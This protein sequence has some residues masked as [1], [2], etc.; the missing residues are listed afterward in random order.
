MTRGRCCGWMLMVVVATPCVAQP[1]AA[2]VNGFGTT[3]ILW[4]VGAT[5]GWRF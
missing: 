2:I 1:S 3:H 5:I 4:V